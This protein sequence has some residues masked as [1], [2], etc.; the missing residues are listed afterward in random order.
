MGNSPAY[1]SGHRFLLSKP[2]VRPASEA[3]VDVE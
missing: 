3:A 2:A 1:S